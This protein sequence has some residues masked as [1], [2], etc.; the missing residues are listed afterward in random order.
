MSR[1]SIKLRVTLFYTA[2]MVL[3]LALTLAFLFLVAGYQ[4][5]GSSHLLLENA[6]KQAGNQVEFEGDYLQI[7]P[8]ID[9]YPDGV[10]LVLY[11]PEG[12]PL[13]GTPPSQFPADT[14]LVS[15][16]FQ[17]ASSGETR[18]QV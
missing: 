5:T 14:P 16:Q 10:T 2:A 1:L 15:D 4:M 6:V 12:T 17:E 9:L 13:L 8:E 7:D 18:W 3:L 11:G